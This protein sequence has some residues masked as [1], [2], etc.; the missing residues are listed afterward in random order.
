MATAAMAQESRARA[1]AEEHAGVS[2]APIDNAR[3]LLRADH[4]DGVVG[5]RR[6][7]LLRDL[8]RVKKSGAGCADI[9]AGRLIRTDFLLHE[10]RGA[11]KEH[12]GRDGRDN[13]QVDFPRGH[14]GVLQC[15]LR[16]FR[17]E[18]AGVLVRRGNSPFLDPGTRDDPLVGRLDQSFELGMV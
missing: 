16:G 2:V 9:K 1:I 10:A 13:D 14:A 17:R 11:W 18:I 12:V 7:E 5:M 6:D 8:D 15:G 3:E 4:Q